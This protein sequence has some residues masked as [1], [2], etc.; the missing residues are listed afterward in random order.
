ML[1]FFGCHVGEHRSGRGVF[2]AKRMREVRVDAG[3]LLLVA[4]GERQNF[5]FAQRVKTLHQGSPYLFA[6]VT[7]SVVPCGTHSISSG[8]AGDRHD[9]T[10]MVSALL[11]GSPSTASRL[12]R[13]ASA[14]A[15][16]NPWKRAEKRQTSEKQSH[17]NDPFN[18]PPALVWIKSGNCFYPIS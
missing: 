7:R 3:I 2:F 5:G 17:N 1:A 12:T 4:N 16:F 10:V 6:L 9:S 15:I 18:R 11:A 13:A 14:T 8:E